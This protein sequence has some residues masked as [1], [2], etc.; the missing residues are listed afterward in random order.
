MRTTILAC[1]LLA[2]TAAAQ[3]NAAAGFTHQR[4]PRRVNFKLRRKAQNFLRRR[5]G[6]I[7]RGWKAMFRRQ[8]VIH[9]NDATTAGGAKAAAD[10]I[11]GLERARHQPAAVQEDQGRKR[12]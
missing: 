7:Q 2:A 6:I 3:S 1:S 11:M 9:R 5:D 4:N 8:P 12:G 10:D